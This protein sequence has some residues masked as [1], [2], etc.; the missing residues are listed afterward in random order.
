MGED[1]TMQKSIERPGKHSN[2]SVPS[3]GS[4]LLQDAKTLVADACAAIGLEDGIQQLL[5]APE[6]EIGVA[7]PVQM[8]DGSLKV[9]HGYRV[10]HSRHRGPAKG[11]FRYHPSVDI[12]EVRALASLMTW[13]CALAGIPYGGAKGGVTCDPSV[14]SEGELARLTRAYARAL[15]P[16]IGSRTDIP[17]PDLN[18]NDRTMAWFMDEIERMTGTY[19]PAIVTG[20][21][22]TVG[23]SLGRGESTGRG[24]AHVARLMLEREGIPV[25]GATVAV[26]GY[27]KVGFH[28][29]ESLVEYGAK[30]IAI[31]DVSAALY[32]PNGL[33]IPRINQHVAST[34]GRLLAGYAGEDA[35]VISAAE[36]LALEC[37][38]LIPAALE[39]QITADNA[40]DIRAKIISEGANGP[41]TL[42]ADE[43]LEANGVIVIP[44]I[45]ANAGGVV[46]S[47]FEWVQGL[48]GR[49]WTLE[50]VREELD[51]IMTTAFEAVV[52]R[53]AQAETS[54]RRAAFLIAVERVAEAA[55]LRTQ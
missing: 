19:D 3:S 46:V 25:E 32:N 38:V 28:A 33:D 17:A 29:V 50:R 20:K 9:F 34:P 44:D 43:I 14:M 40:G 31:S 51:A 49:F 24:V 21:P 6:R 30:I 1:K 2:G 16:V 15:E 53:A 8:D 37:D 26:Q 23:G 13:K 12:D 39:G 45:L 27:G 4:N 11:G 7:L 10:Q 36:L 48:Q 18:T 41:T 42:S 22:V 35:S 5:E 52:N 47:Y 55:R 54:L